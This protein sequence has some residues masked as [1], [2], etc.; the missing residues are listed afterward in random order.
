MTP[1]VVLGASLGGIDAI[2]AVLMAIPSNFPGAIVMVQHRPADDSSRLVDVFARR[3]ALQVTEPE[4]R[5]TIMPGRVYLGPSDYHVMVYG[6]ELYLSMDSPEHFAR[7]SIDV[8]F[9]SAAESGHRPLMGVLL[10]AA[11]A[12]GAAGL[13]AIAVQGGQTIVQDPAEA[14]SPVAV[15]AAL[16]RTTV[17]RVLPVAQ[18]GPALCTWAAQPARARPLPRRI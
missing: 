5:E 14:E 1:L 16:A 8:L 6:S 9:Q 12:D 15:R 3:S 18:I 11:S 17:H 13:Q 4:D 10:T 7:P 2:G